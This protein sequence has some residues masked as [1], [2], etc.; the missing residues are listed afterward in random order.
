MRT[1][2]NFF[3]TSAL[4][5]AAGRLPTTVQAGQV[6]GDCAA[7]RVAVTASDLQNSN[8]NSTTA[9]NV[10]EAAVGFPQG[11][12]GKSCIVV[13]FLAD[14]I[15]TPGTAETLIVGALLDGAPMFPGT[16][17]F[18]SDSDENANGSG[19]GAHAFAWTGIAKPG[20]HM[21]QIQFASLGGN[22]VVINRHTTLVHHR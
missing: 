8:T 16:V 10:P 18:S 17:V 12:N 9:V 22:F 3:L 13:E 20:P 2:K 14:S 21:V 6:T 5:L 1:L 4:V 15:E 7:A 19:M 11:G